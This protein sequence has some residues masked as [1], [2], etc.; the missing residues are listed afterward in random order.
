MRPI[1][2]SVVLAN[3]YLGYVTESSAEKTVNSLGQIKHHDVVVIRGS[4]AGSI[5]IEQIALGDILLLTPGAYVPADARLLTAKNLQIDESILTGES[6]PAQKTHACLLEASLAL[7]D[8]S[9]MVFRGTTVTS[10]SGL[11]IVVATG[12][13]TELGMIQSLMG[14]SSQ[15][16]TPLQKQLEILGKKMV[17]ASLGISV[18]VFGIGILRKSNFVETLKTA[19]SLAVAAIPE[20]LPAVSSVSLATGIR[21]AVKNHH[22]FVRHLDAVETLGNIDVICFDKTGTLTLNEMT[23][24]EIH[25][26]GGQKLSVQDHKIVL[27]NEPVQP[28]AYPDLMQLIK[29]GILCNEAEVKGD[30]MSGSATEIALLYLGTNA[31]IKIDEIRKKFP[32]SYTQYRSEN[33][34]YMLTAHKQEN[35]AEKE[36]LIAAKGQ[37]NEILNRCT[38]YL[39]D[40]RLVELTPK[41]RV[42]I[43]QANTDMA[44]NALRVLGFAYGEAGALSN[45]DGADL[46]WLG[47]VGLLDPC[48]PGISSVISRLQDAGIRTIMITGDQPATALAIGNSLN[49]SGNE[50]INIFDASNLFDLNPEALATLVEQAHIFARVS[51]SHKLHIVQA[52]QRAGKIVAMTGDGINDGPALKVSDIGIAMGGVDADL[53]QRVADLVVAK[54]N[55]S[56][57]IQGVEEGRTIHQNLKKAVSYILSQN[58]SEMIFTLSSV[59]FGFGEPLTPLQLLWVNLVTDILPELALSQELPEFDV[60]E[61]Y[62]R[63]QEEQLVS[64]TDLKRIGGQSL[65]LSLASLVGYLYGVKKYGI[66]PRSRTIGFITLNSAS[67]LHT[68]SSRSDRHSVFSRIRLSDNKYIPMAVALGFAGEMAAVLSPFFRRFLKTAPLPLKDLAFALACSTAPFLIIEGIKL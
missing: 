42:R 53:A 46:V 55:L 24:S 17:G 9:N 49:I 16:E 28:A 31:D 48:R 15:P 47:L 20:G 35:S 39:K 57:L 6:L 34:N 43:E 25:L 8:R 21:E 4:K 27:G 19:V 18:L 30:G 38:H 66:G 63:N 40:G 5:E 61:N 64:L 54:N 65:L 60:L 45:P 44:K 11:A 1:I 3:A 52:L 50:A 2:L 26:P 32:R 62:D 41:V 36:Y 51:P 12:S 68:F 13:A 22:L 23:V 59:L 58:L 37:P 67:L 56:G 7:A 33:Q 14:E 10:G 29:I